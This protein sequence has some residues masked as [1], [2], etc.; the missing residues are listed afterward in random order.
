MLRAPITA[1]RGRSIHR[2]HGHPSKIGQVA[3]GDPCNTRYMPSPASVPRLQTSRHLYVALDTQRTDPCVRRIQATD[4]RRATA[5]HD[6]LSD[7]AAGIV[8]VLDVEFLI[9]SSARTARQEYRRRGL[10]DVTARTVQ[11]VGTPTGLAGLI[12]DIG[13]AGVADGVVLVALDDSA[14]TELFSSTTLPHLLR[15]GIVDTENA[16]VVGAEARSSAREC[17]AHGGS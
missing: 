2:R 10:D 4:L 7:P 9:A 15:L 1:T 3:G 5:V 11:Y 12:A 17:V 13:A 8:A 6:E 16:S 14:S